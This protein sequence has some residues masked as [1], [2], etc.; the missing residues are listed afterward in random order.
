[1]GIRI[2]N[3]TRSSSSTT[4]SDSSTVRRKSEEIPAPKERIPAPPEE[5]P[6]PPEEIP[7]KSRENLVI[8][9]MLKN[10]QISFHIWMIYCIHDTI[11]NPKSN[12]SPCLE[13][14]GKHNSVRITE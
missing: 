7:G 12:I 2:R 13:I 9:G 6:A 10:K 11:S 5:I 3:S 1:M 8:V 4:R 14:L